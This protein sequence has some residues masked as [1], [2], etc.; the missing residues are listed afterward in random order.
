MHSPPAIVV[1]VYDA[2]AYLLPQIAKMPRSHRFSLGAQMEKQLFAILEGTIAAA[3]TRDR[4]KILQGVNLRLENVRHYLRLANEIKCMLGKS[5]EVGSRHVN[6]VG[7]QV[8][9]W[10]RAGATRHAKPS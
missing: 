5:Y 9:G 7:Q 6:S 1:A 8:G 10:L 3:Y 2:I 4:A